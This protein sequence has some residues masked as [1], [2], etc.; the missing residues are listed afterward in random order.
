MS[1]D[2]GTRAADFD[3]KAAC[4]TFDALEKV[5]VQAVAA[6]EFEVAADYVDTL[7]FLADQLD[8]FHDEYRS[9]SARL[10][11]RDAEISHEEASLQEAIIK[12]HR[13]SVQRDHPVAEWFQGGESA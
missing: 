13:W 3:H 7:F 11:D 6:G 12:V 9:E 8:E 4:F 10:A 1:A 5:I 2:T